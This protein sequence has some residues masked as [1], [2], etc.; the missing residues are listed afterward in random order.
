MRGLKK[1]GPKAHTNKQTHKQTD[2][3]GDSMTNSAQKG[4]VGE[5]RLML[6]SG[7]VSS[8]RAASNGA[9]PFSFIQSTFSYDK[10]YMG[11]IQLTSIRNPKVI[12]NIKH[13]TFVDALGSSS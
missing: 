8:E 3:H 5:N 13:N 12:I 11:S 10:Y 1:N 7:G 4:Q 9:T 6:H 2:R